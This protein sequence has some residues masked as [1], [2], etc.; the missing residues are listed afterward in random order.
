MK[1]LFGNY[2]FAG[3]V[4]LCV[5]SSHA[6]SGDHR[7]VLLATKNAEAGD[8]MI[9]VPGTSDRESSIEIKSIRAGVAGSRLALKIDR[10]KVAIFSQ[11]LT[12][13]QCQFRDDASYCDIIVERSS[14]AFGRIVDALEKGKVLKIEITNAGSMV[15]S[16]DVSLIGF[17]RARSQK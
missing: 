2:M 10:Y 1:H 6:L 8:V 13:E 17:R 12:P 9:K 3:L 4:A 11:I 5:H 7:S 14:K 15:M 16:E